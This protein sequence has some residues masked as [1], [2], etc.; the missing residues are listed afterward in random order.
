MIFFPVI[1]LKAKL[2]NFFLWST[3]SLRAIDAFILMVQKE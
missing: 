2:K 1:Q 3:C